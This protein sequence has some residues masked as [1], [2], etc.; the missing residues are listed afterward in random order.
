MPL[1]PIRRRL[2]AVFL[3]VAGAVAETESYI[4][5]LDEA[6]AANEA[7]RAYRREHRARPSYYPIHSGRGLYD[8]FLPLFSQTGRASLRPGMY[9]ALILRFNFFYSV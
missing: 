4:A 1:A 6:F 2:A 8:D 5:R 3:L 9:T 7:D